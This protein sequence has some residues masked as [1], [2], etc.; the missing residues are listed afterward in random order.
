MKT[1]SSQLQTPVES[2]EFDADD[3]SAAHLPDYYT[4]LRSIIRKITKRGVV[5]YARISDP[6]PGG[7]D[8]TGDQLDYLDDYIKSLEQEFGV[9]IPIHGRFSEAV[10]GS[11][12]SRAGRS[13]LVKAGRVGGKF[14]APVVAFD[15]SR[16]VRNED[17]RQP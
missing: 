11:D 3:S 7:R 1:R 16:S 6:K 10:S 5:L 14:K 4:Y 13:E 17:Y 2:N 8:T 9:T 12:F 15:V